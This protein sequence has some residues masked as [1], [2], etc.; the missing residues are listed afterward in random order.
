MKSLKPMLIIILTVLVPFFSPAGADVPPSEKPEVEYLLGLVKTSACKFE[1]NGILYGGRNASE[2]I[3]KKYEHF[4]DKITSTE[5][6]IE[7]AATKSMISGKY[8]LIIC[9]GVEPENTGDWLLKE[10]RKY[11]ESR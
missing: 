4:R 3:E 5:T 8:Y 1:R 9:S 10:L 2:H 11:R 6:F 7:Y